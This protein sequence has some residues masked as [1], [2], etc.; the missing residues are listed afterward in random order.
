VALQADAISLATG[1]PGYAPPVSLSDTST[2]SLP[3]NGSWLNFFRIRGSPGGTVLPAPPG[4]EAVLLLAGSLLLQGEVDKSASNELNFAGL[5]GLF[6]LPTSPIPADDM[7]DTAYTSMSSSTDSRTTLTFSDLTLVNLPP[8]PPASYPV[9]MSTL[10]MWSIDMDRY[11]AVSHL[12]NHHLLICVPSSVESR[13]DQ[14]GV[15]L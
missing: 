10:L 14:V 3:Y 5:Q 15:P 8:G 12:A 2:A 13:C 6:K 11:G 7:N 1:M 9:G 4:P